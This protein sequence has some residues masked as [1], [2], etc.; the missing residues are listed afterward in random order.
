MM[1]E[2]VGPD[3]I[4]IFFGSLSCDLISKPIKPEFMLAVSPEG[5]TGGHQPWP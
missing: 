1:M 3:A 5:I 4:L 2:D